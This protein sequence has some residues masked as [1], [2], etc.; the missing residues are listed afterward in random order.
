M[1]QDVDE[2]LSRLLA[3]E[4]VKIPGCPVRSAEQITFDSPQV[5]EATL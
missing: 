5:A 4:L 3:G 2:T 1:I